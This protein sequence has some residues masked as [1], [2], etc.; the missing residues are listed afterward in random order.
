MSNPIQRCLEADEDTL[1]IQWQE[2]LEWLENRFGKKAGIESILFL[3]G[4]QSRG[5]GYEPKLSKK[6]KQDLI[7][8]G[9]YCV[10]E[11]LGLYKRVGINEKGHIAW[12]KGEISYPV[13][14]LPEQ[15]KLLKG[16]I[17]NYFESLKH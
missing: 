4:I 6:A 3:I 1:T 11:T 9:T 10:F 12:E 15:E 2:L 5:R 17:L 13:L 8:E 16:A 7:M 14:T